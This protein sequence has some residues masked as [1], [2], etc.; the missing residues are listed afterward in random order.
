M[1]VVSVPASAAEAVSGRS[2]RPATAVLHDS[3]DARVV[4]FRIEPGQEVTPHTSTSTVLLSVVEGRGMV[5]GALGER[6]V[7]AGD[8]VT[9]DVGE[10]HGMRAMGERLVIAAVIA[11]RPG[12]R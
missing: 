2:E 4:V 6:A 8:L 7:I 1:N 11:P 12:S 3:P 5:S 9:Y 10:L